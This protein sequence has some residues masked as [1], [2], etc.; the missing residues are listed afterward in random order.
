MLIN[1]LHFKVLKCNLARD[2]MRLNKTKNLDQ[3]VERQEKPVN[4]KM[5][6]SSKQLDYK[7]YVAIL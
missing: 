3:T 7:D 4:T 1:I 2:S 5:S 6:T